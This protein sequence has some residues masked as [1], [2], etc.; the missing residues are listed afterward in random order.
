MA[1]DSSPE[2]VLGSKIGTKLNSGDQLSG[3]GTPSPCSSYASLKSKSTDSMSPPASESSSKSSVVA[4]SPVAVPAGHTELDSAGPVTVPLENDMLISC[5]Q[6]SGE[7]CSQ[8]KPDPTENGV[9]ASSP[10]TKSS[11]EEKC[12]ISAECDSGENNI[13]RDS[14]T[15]AASSAK[16]LIGKKEQVPESGHV[17][18]DHLENVV[19]KSTDIVNN[20]DTILISNGS[21]CDNVCTKTEGSDDLCCNSSSLDSSSNEKTEIVIS[22]VVSS[23]RKT[24]KKRKGRRHIQRT[25]SCDMK[26]LSTLKKRIVN[27]DASKVNG[28]KCGSWNLEI[29]P[30]MKLVAKKVECGKVTEENNCC[31]MSLLKVS[32]ASTVN[33]SP[34]VGKKESKTSHCSSNECR[35]LRRSERLHSVQTDVQDPPPKLLLKSISSDDGVTSGVNEQVVSNTSQ[36]VSVIK[37]S[38]SEELPK[39]TERT[40]TRI[41][42]N[43][44]IT[45]PDDTS[46]QESLPVV[47]V[48]PTSNS[49]SKVLPR[50]KRGRPIGSKN[51]PRPPGSEKEPKKLNKKH[52]SLTDVPTVAASANGSDLLPRKSTS[53]SSRPK[54]PF[55]HLCGTR[56]RPLGVTVV[57]V[58]SKDEESDFKSSRWKRFFSDDQTA[59]KSKMLSV[60]FRSTMSAH[61]DVFTKDKTWV[62]ALC[63]RGSHHKGLGDLFG[64]YFDDNVAVQ[65]EKMTNSGNK[66]DSKVEEL[67]VAGRKVREKRK[68]SEL[69]EEFFKSTMAKKVYFSR[70]SR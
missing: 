10:E 66:A 65:P 33:Q 46:S 41:G 21:K 32:P 60:G 4:A 55:L 12:G 44:E 8:Q 6:S 56:D 52:K 25:V 49:E 27:E 35:S 57:N 17:E 53:E 64:P 51:K 37:V 18:K 9:T 26:P 19:T 11:S 23:E 48:S 54:G 42:I 67:Q 28:E 1:L 38:S 22:G 29:S 69:V 15:N 7:A 20:H 13:S 62:C 40:D 58:S 30:E 31:D 5:P 24:V 59:P 2:V 14:T 50:R 3:C 68:R 43:L 16:R 47:G 34:A 61:Y 36:D 63:H 70:F 45:V 39:R